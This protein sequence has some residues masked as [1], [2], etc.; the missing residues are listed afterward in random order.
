MKSI[1]NKTITFLT[2]VF[3]PKEGFVQKPLEK[4]YSEIIFDHCKTPN[5][6]E[7]GFSYEEIKQIT[8]IETVCDKTKESLE[9][10]DAD[11]DFIKNKIKK[12]NW[13]FY[14]KNIID[15]VEYIINL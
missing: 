13:G 9:V 11:L 2:D 5:N 1:K 4:K 8:R 6:P 14:D 10:E 15:F 3:I 12:A 7:K